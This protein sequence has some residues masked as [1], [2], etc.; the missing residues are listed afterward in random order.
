[1]YETQ[2]LSLSGEDPLEKVM[3]T[4]YSIF[5]WRVP[6]TE[7]SGGL[8]F[9]RLQRWTQLS[10]WPFHFSNPRWCSFSPMLS[11]KF[12]ICLFVLFWFWGEGCLICL[13]VCFT[14]NLVVH[15][16]FIFVMDIRPSSFFFFLLF[17][18]VY[19]YFFYFTC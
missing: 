5:A 1:M 6:W 7:E 14:I 2:V 13:S 12:F 9:S 10:S 11:F 8:Q 19:I 17:S 3:A 16:E 15:A 4:H 18:A